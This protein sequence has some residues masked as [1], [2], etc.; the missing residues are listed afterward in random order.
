MALFLDITENEVQVLLEEI[1]T[2]MGAFDVEV[3]VTKEELIITLRYALGQFEKEAGIWQLNNQF[4]NIYGQPAGLALTNQI[5]TVN[6]NLT[7]QVTDWFAAMQRVGGK[8]PWHKD[9]ITLEPGRQVYFLDKESSRPYP[10]GTRRIHRVFWVA[11]PELFGSHFT[12]DYNQI[13]GDDILYNNA[14]NFTTSGLNYGDNRLGFLG[15][16]FD[17]VLMLQAIETRNKILFSEFFH[18]LSGD[19]LEITPMPGKALSDI[20]PGTRVFYYYWNEA[21]VLS[22]QSFM[23]NPANSQTVYSSIEQLDPLNPN[24][25]TGLTGLP[26]GQAILIANPLQMNIQA[27]PWSYLSA[28]AQAVV[29]NIAFARCKYIQA[30][31]WR[32]IKKTFAT[33]EMEYEVE[34][35][36]QSLLQEATD[37]ENRALDNLREDFK[38][39][40]IGT[41][42]Q[43]QTQIVD[44]AVQQSKRGGR[45]WFIGV[46]AFLC[47]SPYLI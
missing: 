8:I 30:A 4:I 47:L 40:N 38:D 6:F 39:L 13:H 34:F 12:G 42:M 46:A 33:G 21:E 24:N 25:N 41:L 2:F 35:D 26:A 22:G 36:Y 37:E 28:W 27:V 7:R 32:K 43:Q 45:L 10:T 17:T 16:T 11:T 23:N 44:S 5:A 29:K 3:D 14:W 18:N 19:V 1:V 20:Q 15:Y 9:Y 31:K